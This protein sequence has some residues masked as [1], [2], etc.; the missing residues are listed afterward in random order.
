MKKIKYRKVV[1]VILLGVILA[2]VFR[3]AIFASYVVDGESMEP[4]LND[5][6]LLMVN[7]VV[8]DLA[9]VDRFDVIVFHANKQEDYV[10]RVIGI[11]GDEIE[12]RD[13]KL[14][15]N[16]KYVEEEFLND[17][18]KAT[19]GEKPYTENFN[20]KEVTGKKTVPNGKLF[21]M[22]DNR[23]DSLDSRSFGFISQTQLVGK[24]DVKY[25]PLSQASLS[26]GK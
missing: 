12:Y 26:L 3:T 6:N 16:G 15:I 13:D 18:A 22:G 23:G 7:K 10:K 24:V 5:G 14:Y 25:W 20:L 1:P 4:T 2:I 17:Y 8:Y 21:V 19:T 9:D 11:P